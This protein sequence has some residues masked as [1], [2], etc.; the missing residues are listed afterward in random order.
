MLIRVLAVVLSAMESGAI[1][2][3]GDWACESGEI[4]GGDSLAGSTA[5]A[6]VTPGTVMRHYLC[7]GRAAHAPL[8]HARGM[9]MSP[10]AALL[11]AITGLALSAQPRDGGATIGAVALATVTLAANQDLCLAACA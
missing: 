11:V 2:L 3:R 4:A 9:L 10:G 6:G 8:V 1:E 7:C 5:S